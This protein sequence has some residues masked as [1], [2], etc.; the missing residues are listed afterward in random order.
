MLVRIKVVMFLALVEANLME[1]SNGQTWV[2]GLG[3]SS[4]YFGEIHGSGILD[5]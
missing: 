1:V 2:F 4:R 5:W 3:L